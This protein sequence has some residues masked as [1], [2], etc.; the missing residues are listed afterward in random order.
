[1][2]LYIIMDLSYIIP[3]L[4]AAILIGYIII[5]LKHMPTNNTWRQFDNTFIP[6]NQQ[7]IINNHITPNSPGVPSLEES[8]VQNMINMEPQPPTSSRAEPVLNNFPDNVSIL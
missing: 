6:T 4:L 5:S 8:A 1:M 3:I 7:E 2:K